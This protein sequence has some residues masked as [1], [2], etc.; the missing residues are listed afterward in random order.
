VS[1]RTGEGLEELRAAIR[2]RMPT[3]RWKELVPAYDD[4]TGE[5]LP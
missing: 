1:A 2:A 5:E 4:T 3:P